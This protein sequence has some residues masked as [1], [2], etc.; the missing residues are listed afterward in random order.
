MLAVLS[1]RN[2]SSVNQPLLLVT[3]AVAVAE[4]PPP[5]L[6]FTVT[7][8][9]AVRTVEPEVP[10]TVMFAVPSV[11]VL[12]AVSVS[13]ELF[14]VVDAGLKL[15][16]TP[17]GK[18]LAVN[19]TLPGKLVRLS[20]TAAVV[21][22]PRVTAAVPGA[23]TVKLDAVVPLCVTDTARVTP[24]P[25]TVTVPLRLVVPVLAVALTVKLPLPEPLVGDAL[26]QV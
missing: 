22:A 11:A 5:P 4:P 19:V 2:C 1:R 24:P 12:D 13:V 21:L 16:V 10:V 20:V 17:D 9:V 25:V 23:E 8:I 18:P 7:A 26:S 6:L 14:P 15:A 3:A